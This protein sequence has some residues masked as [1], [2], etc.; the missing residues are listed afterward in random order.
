[1]TVKADDHRGLAIRVEHNPGEQ[2]C[3]HSR[4]ETAAEHEMGIE[5]HHFVVDVLRRNSNDIV[6]WAKYSKGIPDHVAIH[7]WLIG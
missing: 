5:T 3:P 1:M 4:G 6:L 7:A 2:A